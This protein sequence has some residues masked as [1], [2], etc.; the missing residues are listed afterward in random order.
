MS[1]LKPNNL[2]NIVKSNFGID[3]VAVDGL[4][5]FDLRNVT[6]YTR[7]PEDY[8]VKNYG[9]FEMQ[10]FSSSNGERYKLIICDDDFPSNKELFSAMGQEE[11]LDVKRYELIKNIKP[12]NGYFL[13]R[14]VPFTVQREPAWF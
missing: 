8:T 12:T 1:N 11:I 4:E 7:Y 9:Y 13:Y 3:A 14:L 10:N 6:V 2:Q 5:S